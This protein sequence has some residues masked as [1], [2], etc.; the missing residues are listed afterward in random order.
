MCACMNVCL[1]KRGEGTSSVSTGKPQTLLCAAVTLSL[2]TPQLLAMCPA[3][4]LCV[5]VLPSLSE[6]PLLFFFE[7]GGVYFLYFFKR[8]N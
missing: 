6:M 3:S 4:A 7:G 1:A 2:I 8:H 5:C